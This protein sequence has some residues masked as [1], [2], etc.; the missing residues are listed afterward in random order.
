M[1]EC[2]LLSSIQIVEKIEKSHQWA[3]NAKVLYMILYARA[4]ILRKN[5]RI[6]EYGNVYLIFPIDE[7]SVQISRQ[8]MR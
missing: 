8:E 7:L 2:F 4:R 5:S 6:D 1:G 3:Q